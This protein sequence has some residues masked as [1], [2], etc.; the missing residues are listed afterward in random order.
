[1][2]SKPCTTYVVYNYLKLNLQ[3]QYKEFIYMFICLLITHKNIYIY[4]LKMGIQM[5]IAEDIMIFYLESTAEN[6]L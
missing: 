1:M 5:I 4:P 6:I 3:I 2:E